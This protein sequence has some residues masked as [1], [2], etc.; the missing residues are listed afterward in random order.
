MT[1]ANAERISE[2]LLR[3]Q[4]RR[5]QGEQPAIEEL[6]A[7]HPELIEDLRQRI[8]ALEAMENFLDM[9]KETSR[10]DQA[11]NP[12]GSTPPFPELRTT[13]APSREQIR[14]PGYEILQILG[15]GG[16]GIVYK[17]RQ[18]KP[19]RLVAIKMIPAGYDASSDQLRRFRTETEA[20]AQL[21]H[22]HIVPILEVGEHEGRPYFSMEYVEGGNL[23]DALSGKV[24]PAKSAAKLI[25]TLARSMQ[26][27]H[28]HGIVH[29]DLK[30]SN[31]L[32]QTA[33][34]RNGE[35]TKTTQ[36]GSYLAGSLLSDAV[37]K[38]SDFGL[39]RRLDV[40]ADQT[41]SGAVLGTPSYLAP[42]QAEGKTRQ[43]GP[44]AD[45]YALGAILYETLTGR[46]PFQGETVLDTLEQV[47]FQE[48]VS[49]RRLQPKAP[50]DLE[51]ICLKCL[52]KEPSRR[53]VSAAALAD[54][55]GR[56]LAGEPI[57]A[58]PVGLWERTAKWAR[59]RPAVAS[60]LVVSVLA[61]AGLLALWTGFT[62][63]LTIERN[64][65]RD[66]QRRAQEQE[67]IANENRQ[68]AETQRARAEIE[69]N[70]A[71][72]EQRHAQEQERVAEENRKIAEAQRARAEAVLY[73]CLA[74][75]EDNAK[76]TMNAKE[77]TRKPGEPHRLLFEVARYY[78][79]AATAVQHSST[80][81]EEDRHRL[82]D[83]YTI[84]AV[85]MLTKA[86]ETGYFQ[87]PANRDKLRKEKDLDPLRSRD[88]FKRLMAKV[89]EG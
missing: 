73:R 61:V 13:P 32:L 40:P 53:Y 89:N 81:G 20:A 37:P 2:L 56:F 50:R 85:R 88:D 18:L 24:M 6:C 55:L 16:M 8:Q 10:E 4:E 58:R 12:P 11:N 28:D 72:D 54:D 22:P 80:M 1:P 43:A 57:Q 67:G 47:R 45:I 39:A 64:H 49:I 66:E 46:P 5:D 79:T 31:I 83:R 27:A 69:R 35:E 34:Q 30:P 48:P 84:N 77:A 82:A 78:A 29:R 36:D 7:G 15:R 62:S 26:Y 76:A 3:W 23:A 52:H 38:I 14:L 51:T 21:R 75:I 9:G 44:A 19:N 74:V 87:D 70:H 63:R 68:T 71:R 25:E 17:A 60:L 41:Q 86:W 59:R 42:E 33:V 65:A